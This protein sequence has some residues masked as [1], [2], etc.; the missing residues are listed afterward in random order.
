M[1]LK[2]KYIVFTSNSCPSEWYPGISDFDRAAIDRRITE[3]TCVE[4]YISDPAENH[5]D[6]FPQEHE[7]QQ[8]PLSEKESDE[9]IKAYEEESLSCKFV[10]KFESACHGA[11]KDC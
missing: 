9:E 7:P 10:C 6:A 4:E 5:Y 8:D 11:I 1:W 2:P 3:I